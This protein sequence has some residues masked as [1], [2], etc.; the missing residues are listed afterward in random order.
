MESLLRRESLCKLELRVQS[1]SD[2]TRSAKAM[3]V[4]NRMT[5]DDHGVEACAS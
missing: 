2:A 4:A 1:R 3:E 5:S